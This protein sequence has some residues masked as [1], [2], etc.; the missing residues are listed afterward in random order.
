MKPKITNKTVQL[1]YYSRRKFLGRS[2][3]VFATAA[4]GPLAHASGI[5]GTMNIQNGSDLITEKP[6]KKSSKFEPTYGDYTVVYDH[7]EAI[8]M[9]N[10]YILTDAPSLVK[11]IDGALLCSVPF[12]IRGIPKHPIKT[13]YF[14]R[15]DDNGLSWTKLPG[16]STF[17]CGTLFKHKEALYFIGAGPGHRDLNIKSEGIRIIRSNDNGNTW[18]DPII[19][20]NGPFYQPA[21]GYVIRDGQFYW[22]CDTGRDMTYVIAGDISRDLTDPGA[23]RISE[24]LPMPEVPKSLTRGPG[25]GKILEGNVVEVNGRLQVSWRYMIDER[26]T[27]GIG[28]ICDLDDNVNQLK[29]SFRQFYPLPGAQNQFY[30]IYDEVSGLYWMNA[31]LPTHTQDDDFAKVL[32]KNPRYQGVPG[33]ERRILALF[34]S[35]DALNWLPAGY[36]IVWPL[37]RQSTNYCGMLIDGDDL[38]VVSRTSRNGRNQHDNDL[39]TFHRVSNFRDR[40]SH[41]IS[42]KEKI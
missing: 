12:M 31:N 20:F 39:T 29:Y 28:V 11:T 23:W 36:I 15:S 7:Y 18:T 2:I 41:L 6:K 38:L 19:L 9:E 35:F 42:K 22:C 30:I 14:F 33:K 5:H 17:V 25:K 13:L 34:C 32:H 24:G 10:G 16:E 37:V 1:S 27:V 4:I 21:G 3:G 40:A 8:P 26:D